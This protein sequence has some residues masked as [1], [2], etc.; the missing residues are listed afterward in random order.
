MG[1]PPMMWMVYEIPGDLDRFTVVQWEVTDDDETIQRSSYTGTL[2]DVRR[3]IPP[4][5]Q[6]LRAPVAGDPST[7]VESWV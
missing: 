4:G 7:V 1:K 2:D 6:R 5:L 3:H